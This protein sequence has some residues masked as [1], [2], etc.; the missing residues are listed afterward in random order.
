MK[1]LSYVLTLPLMGLAIMW[2]PTMTIT[3]PLGQDL[4]GL[5]DEATSQS[6]TATKSSPPVSLPQDQPEALGHRAERALPVGHRPPELP[7]TMVADRG[8]EMN[9]HALVAPVAL[10]RSGMTPSPQG[11]EG[12]RGPPTPPDR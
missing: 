6:G 4:N 7:P 10:D 8:N 5:G 12:W 9:E 3:L 2:F 11:P 1:S